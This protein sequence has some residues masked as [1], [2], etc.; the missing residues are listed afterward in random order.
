MTDDHN[1]S[2]VVAEHLDSMRP[3]INKLGS[4][5]SVRRNPHVAAVMSEFDV[6][7]DYVNEELDEGES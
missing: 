1:T 2:L 7:A 6:L 5:E 3:H 4:I